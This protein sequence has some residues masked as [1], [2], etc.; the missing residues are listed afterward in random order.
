MRQFTM[1]FCVLSAFALA[2]LHPNAAPTPPQ[3]ASLRDP[4]ALVLPDIDDTPITAPEVGITTANLHTIRLLVRKPFADAINY[5]K[6][7]TTINGESAGTIQSINAGRDGYIVTCK[8]DDKPHLFRLHSGKNV[9]EIMATDRSN[10]LYYASYVLLTGGVTGEVTAGSATIESIP[11]SSG[12]DHQPPTVYLIE[13]KSAVRVTGRTAI[14]RVYGVASDDSGTVAS[15]TINGQTVPLAA[16]TNARGVIVR[17]ADST[18]R[19]DVAFDQTV[20]LPAEAAA[21]VIE[22]KDRAGNIARM[23]VPVLRRVAAVSSRFSGRKFA[24]VVGVSRYQ[25]HESGLNDLG[26]ADAD[27]R[28]IRD[29]LQKA[30]GG[31]FAPSDIVYLENEQATIDGVRAAFKNFLPKA[32]P[33]D[34]VFIF[35]AGHGSP[36]PYAPQNLYYLMHNTKVAN[37][38]G[39]ALPMDELK[40]V[41]E[42]SVRAQ[43]VVV[44]IDTCH[45]AG[46]SGAKLVQSR[47]LE[48]N[49]VNLY[50]QKLFNETGRAILTSSDVNELSQES[51]QWGGGH[52][53]FTQALLE[54][55][56]GEADTN[57]DHLI[58]AGELF[59][60][61]RN[62]VR[63][64]TAF[65]Q[66][67]RVLP[68]VNAD[69]T[70]VAVPTK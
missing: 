7:H 5:G 47:G 12:S 25:Y 21:V 15:V 34:L 43:R 6:I 70:L 55:F 19:G 16:A 45:S 17:P 22:A 59:D 36:D 49:L 62:R 50:A 8:L 69:L 38:S 67:P 39:T 10:H 63:V 60:Y 48:N 13:P 68:G 11:T 65:Q 51:Q 52:G 18:P 9:V 54:G 24:L 42:H 57:G 27:A 29:Y 44:F 1:T 61:V 46:L 2:T 35:I 14:V 40:D 23:R 64:A 41:L 32:G 53:I 28:A 37:M 30:E 33:N 26:Y 20:T 56:R 66:N 3:T 58:T 31:G 4:F